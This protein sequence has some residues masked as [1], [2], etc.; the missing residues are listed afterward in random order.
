MDELVG[1]QPQ[2][3]DSAAD[4]SA[5]GSD[6]EHIVVSNEGRLRTI[7]MNRPAKYNALNFKVRKC[8]YILHMYHQLLTTSSYHQLLLISIVTKMHV[9]VHVQSYMCVYTL[10]LYM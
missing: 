9:H 3:S 10:L 8:T 6:Y 7:L 5:G 1:S 4:P 2:T